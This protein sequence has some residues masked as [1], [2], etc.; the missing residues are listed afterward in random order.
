MT[1]GTIDRVH[2]ATAELPPKARLDIHFDAP[3]NKRSRLLSNEKPDLL[4]KLESNDESVD[5]QPKKGPHMAEQDHGTHRVEIRRLS[6]NLACEI[7]CSPSDSIGQIKAKVEAEAGFAPEMMSL[8]SPT[9]DRPL[10]KN[11]TLGS[12]G[13]PSEL[14]AVILHKVNIASDIAGV[15]PRLL[16]DGQ[17]VEACATAEGKAGDVIDVIGCTQLRDLTCLLSLE[18]MQVL[19][20]SGCTNIDATALGAVLATHKTLTKITFGANHL[21]RLP[22]ALT[23]DFCADATGAAAGQPSVTMEAS[24]T[25]ADFSGNRLGVSDVVLLSAFLPKCTAL[26]SLDMSNTQLVGETG[27]GVFKTKV[28]RFFGDMQEVEIM[29]PDT[30]GVVTLANAIKDMGAM[31]KLNLSK[32][33]LLTKEGGR[34]LGNM[35]KANMFLKELDVSNSGYGMISDKDAS[36]FAEEISEGLA[37]NGTLM[38]LN[39][40]SNHLKAE[41]AKIV[42]SRAIKVTNYEI[43]V[44]LVPFVCLSD[45]WLN[46]CLFT[47]IHRITGR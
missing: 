31:T 13:L 40:S 2:V 45:H 18:N 3:A 10:G 21:R 24:M 7:V 14:F 6:G 11:E 29:E 28:S 4:A 22:L 46:C 32:N 42:M 34:A 19:D 5:K 36:G 15:A 35:L 17:L 37:G 38:S 20:V 1:G 39:L 26:T 16:I 33:G 30:S 25:A 43:A 8:L 41:G 44:V 12:C 27:T 47:A 23:K 9:C